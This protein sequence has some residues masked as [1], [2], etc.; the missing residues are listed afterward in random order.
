MASPRE[1]PLTE[2]EFV[3]LRRPIEEASHVPG[4]LYHSPEIFAL[5]KQRIFLKDWL[6]V[7]RVEEF[8]H[9][10][11]Y[12]TFNILGEPIVVLRNAAGVLLAL[13]N[14]CAH[15]GVEVVSGAG[16]AREFMCPYHGWLYDLD[17]S[18]VGTPYMREAKDFDAKSCR[19]PPLRLESWAGW[20]FVCFDPMAEPLAAFVTEFADAFGFLRQEDCVAVDKLV[21]EVDCNW[22]LIVENLLDT[23]HA[24]VVH[25]GTFGAP[26]KIDKPAALAGRRLVRR[27][28]CV[29]FYEAAPHTYS[30]KP[31]VGKMPALD[32]KP[33]SFAASG[34]LAPNMHFFARCENMRP[35]VHWPLG[36]KR[37][38]L[39]Y[40]NLFPR[41]FVGRPGFEQVVQAY[42]QFYTQAFEEDRAVLISLQNAMESE[43]VRPGRMSKLETP[44]H[45]ELNY[46]LDRIL[47]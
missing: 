32:D 12:R 17:G 31:L 30:G 24:A 10:G 29:N 21:F 41:E 46:Y 39:V 5:E 13:G 20:V 18:A 23:Y 15:R 1:R 22:K 27:G 47:G 34:Y 16:E 40:Y 8:P 19:L 4:R 2:A 37:T 36:V 28:G 44:I 35:C 45:H 6:C 7:G 42:R 3:E 43:L 14:V 38:R 25:A 26:I 9:P 11:S 33:E